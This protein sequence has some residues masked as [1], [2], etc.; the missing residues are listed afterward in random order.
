MLLKTAIKTKMV[1]ELTCLIPSDG[2]NP[3]GEG[4]IITLLS[5]GGGCGVTTLA[6]NLANELALASDKESLLVDLDWFYG[7][8]GPYL[9]LQGNYGI[10]DLLARDDHVDGQL[11]R[12]TAVTYSDSLHVLL[13]PASITTRHNEAVPNQ[14]LNQVLSACRQTYAHTIIDAARV[15]RQVAAT[16]AEASTSVM[17]VF[18]LTVKDI[19]K[20]RAERTA[21]IE[22]GIP[23]SRLVLVANRYDKRSS[24]TL[25]DARIALGG[26]PVNLIANDYRAAVHNV[27]FG[28]PL[29]ETAPTSI[30]RRDINM[31]WRGLDYGTITNQLS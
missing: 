11:V 1:A 13:S 15:S 4:K 25:D 26:L 12:S 20:I 17:L 19:H 10:A 21:L 7:A 27:N 30:L 6:F 29:S 18:Q 23:E 9:G 8:L 5:G 14:N 28:R 3:S 22:S 16:L 31:F 24:V 2:H